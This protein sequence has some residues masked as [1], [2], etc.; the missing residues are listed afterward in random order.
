MTRVRTRVALL[1]VAFAAC[2][3][4]GPQ[5]SPLGVLDARDLPNW[6]A[7]CSTPLAETRVCGRLA[8]EKC[9]RYFH[10]IQP[11]Q[12]A[13]IENTPGSSATLKRACASE[14]WAVWTDAS[15]RVVGFCMAQP[16]ETNEWPRIHQFV[17]RH[18]NK[19]IAD[20]ILEKAS[21]HCTDCPGWRSWAEDGV[22]AKPAEMRGVEGCIEFRLDP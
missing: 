12:G 8:P 18:R 3:D 15:D 19:A 13:L 2:H 6:Q 17:E 22:V 20:K 21:G 10:T 11:N 5:P 7:E 16:P 1:L 9:D 4:R 14:G